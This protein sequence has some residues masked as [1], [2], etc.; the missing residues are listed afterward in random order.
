MNQ[1]DVSSLEL[2]ESNIMRTENEN[3]AETHQRPSPHSKFARQMD[4]NIC[5]EDTEGATAACWI[6]TGSRSRKRIEIRNRE[7]E[8]SLPVPNLGPI[9]KSVERISA[10]ETEPEQVFPLHPIHAIYKMKPERLNTFRIW[11][12]GDIVQPQML[13]DAGFFYTGQSS[14][15]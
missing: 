11:K 7:Q 14:L 12:F 5:R 15:T 3:I 9:D 2:L 13:V 4:G 1:K 6:E 10:I 8:D